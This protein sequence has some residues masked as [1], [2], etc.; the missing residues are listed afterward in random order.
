MK[1]VYGRKLLT[2]CSKIK[3]KQYKRMTEIAREFKKASLK[4]WNTERM[5][6]LMEEFIECEQ[7]SNAM[8]SVVNVMIRIESMLP[9]KQPKPKVMNPRGKS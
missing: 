1:T 7:H 4:D 5:G 2:E 8:Q 3:D 9:Q 6:E